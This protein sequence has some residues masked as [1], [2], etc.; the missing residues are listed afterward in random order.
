MPEFVFSGS[1]EQ[2]GPKIRLH[3]HDDTLEILFYMRGTGS[4]RVGSAD[5]PFSPGR[6]VFMPQ[7]IEHGESSRATFGCLF[8][9][10][11]GYTCV[12]GRT[13]I[14]NDDSS[15]SVSSIARML[16]REFH[17]K[18]QG[19]ERITQD[20]LNLLMLLFARWDGAE[21]EDPWVQALKGRLVESMHNPDF[22]VSEALD[23]LLICPEHARRMFARATGKTP[24]QYLNALRVEEAKQLLVTGGLSVKEVAQRV[25]VPDPFYFSRLFRKTVGVSPLIYSQR[26]RR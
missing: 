21:P 24:L 14:Y 22:E 5:I 2:A 12:P 9:H 17:L 11:K 20:L 3:K 8:V 23:D 19:W 18:Q 7:G 16:N 6:I 4:V 26:L 10:I 15:G 13:P 1:A 25:G